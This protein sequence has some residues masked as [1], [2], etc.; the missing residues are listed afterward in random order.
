MAV[1][2]YTSNGE[3][4]NL[5]RDGF[6]ILD[7]F[8]GYYSFLHPLITELHEKTGQ[9]IDPWGDA[10]FHGPDLVTLRHTINAAQDLVASQPPEWDVYVGDHCHYDDQQQF[11]RDPMYTKVSKHEFSDLLENISRLIERA[12]SQNGSV[13]CIGD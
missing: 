2:I 6:V 10:T 4:S 13:V 12:A 9:L 3:P 8:D 5:N 7:V 11:V 1:H